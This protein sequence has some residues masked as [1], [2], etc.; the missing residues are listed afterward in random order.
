MQWARPKNLG[1]FVKTLG[2]FVTQLGQLVT[3]PRQ[4]VTELGQWWG[5]HWHSNRG[6]VPGAVLGTTVA[7]PWPGWGQYCGNA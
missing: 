3:E 7:V 2:Q 4:F 1:Q 6:V 5:Q